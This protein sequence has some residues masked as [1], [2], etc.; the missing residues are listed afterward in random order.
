MNNLQ[1]TE[2]GNIRVLTTQQLADEYEAESQILTNNYNRNKERYLEGKHFICLA[3]DDLKEF[4]ATN[5]NDVLPNANKLYLWTQKGA[6]LH[7]KSLNT[8]RAWEVYDHLVDSYF[9]KSK[10]Y[11][12]GL[13]EELKAV[14]VVDKRVTTVESRID[15]LENDMPMHAYEAEQVSNHVKRKGVNVLGGKDSEAYHDL[16][17]RRKVYSDIYTQM[18]REF[19]G[20]EETKISYKA[21][22]RKYLADV[23]DFIDCYEPPVSLQE[24]IDDANAQRRMAM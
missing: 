21:I 19:I 22:K 2:Y 5:Q 7:A 15:K 11:L 4:R 9:D 12:D 20:P 16:S 24:L 13:S 23:H 3:G 14:F 8:D 6:F 10:N 18:K 1:E 17:I